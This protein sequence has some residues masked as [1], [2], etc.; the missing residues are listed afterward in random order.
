M[1]VAVKFPKSSQND[2]AVNKALLDG[3]LS[4]Y[5]RAPARASNQGRAGLASVN[6]MHR[7]SHYKTNALS[8]R[9]VPLQPRRL[10]LLL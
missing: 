7:D 8:V 5:G 9:N 10:A 3:P 1:R 6:Q 2:Y 4:A